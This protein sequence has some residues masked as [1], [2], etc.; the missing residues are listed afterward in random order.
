MVMFFCTDREMPN[1]R[2]FSSFVSHIGGAPVSTGTL[3]P[4]LQAEA[5]LA[6][7]KAATKVIANNDYAYAMA[8]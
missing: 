7:L 3:K 1:E 8:A 5:P 2:G 4:W 6:S